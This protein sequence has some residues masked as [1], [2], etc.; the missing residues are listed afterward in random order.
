V[1]SEPNRL[2]ISGGAVNASGR[3]GSELILW[4]PKNG[5]LLKRY[6]KHQKCISALAVSRDGGLLASGDTAGNVLLWELPAM[7][8]LGQVSTSVGAEVKWLSFGPDQLFVGTDDGKLRKYKI[9]P[10]KK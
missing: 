8:Q 7:T 1:L 6:E 2:I 5:K 9:T 4:D 10:S 3:A